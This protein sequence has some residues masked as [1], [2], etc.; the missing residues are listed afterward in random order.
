MYPS[1][2]IITLIN[3]LY[4]CQSIFLLGKSWGGTVGTAYLLDNNRQ[5]KIKGWIE[6]DGAHNLKMGIPLSWE[7]VKEKANEQ[8]SAGKNAAYWRGEIAWY[9]SKPGSFDTKYWMRHG[10]N[11]NDLNGI[12]HN[13]DNDPGNFFSFASPVPV[14]YQ[15]TT[16]HL[17]NN[18]KFDLKNI[19]F[20][21]EIYKIT[22][23]VMILWGR[24]DGTLPVDLAQDAYDHVGTVLADKYI[25]IFENSAHCPSFEEPELWLDRMKEFVEK[26]R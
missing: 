23:P 7:W 17:T 2:T 3:Q 25:H 15:M 9:N 26:Y 22:I 19:D 21:P 11:I 1:H 6:E 5:N 16:L 14:F 8:I 12:Y 24:Y 13:P 4:H 20:T 10:K 18:N